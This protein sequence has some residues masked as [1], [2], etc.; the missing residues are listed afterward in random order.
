MATL[1]GQSIM[2]HPAQHPDSSLASCDSAATEYL[3]NNPAA[4]DTLGK[5]QWPIPDTKSDIELK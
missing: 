3:D 5:Q 4:F 1:S 2:F